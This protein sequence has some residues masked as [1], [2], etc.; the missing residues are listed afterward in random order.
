VYLYGIDF[1]LTST[2]VETTCD[3]ET[4][5]GTSESNIF[6]WDYTQAI[7]SF[8]APTAVYYGE[9]DPFISESKSIPGYF[10]G[11]DV[12]EVEIPECGH[13]WEECADDF[14]GRASR[15]LADAL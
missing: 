11:T 5:F 10:T 8:S 2:L 7:R 3:L 1:P 13:Y 6:G 4:F 9:A 14:F 12:E 15:F